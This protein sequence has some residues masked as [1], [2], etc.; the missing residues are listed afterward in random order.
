MQKTKTLNVREVI[1]SKS[2]YTLV[3]TLLVLSIFLIIM[4]ISIVTVP[5]YV[6]KREIESF[7]QQLSHDLH[8][9]Q[10]LALHDQTLYRVNLNTSSDFYMITQ[11]TKRVLTRE[12]P[13]EVTFVRGSST[14]NSVITAYANGSLSQTGTWIFRSKHY[15][16]EFKTLLGEGRHYYHEQ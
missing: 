15:T 1:C 4:V 9:A 3:E 13:E 10:A 14:L 5:R 16:Y 2:G 11:N 6:E 7:L 8:Y 12:F